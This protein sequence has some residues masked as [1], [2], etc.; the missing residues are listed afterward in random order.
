MS[1]NTSYRSYWT[2]ITSAQAEIVTETFDG[3]P[4]NDLIDII[5]IG[6]P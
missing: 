6:P 5:A 2:G 1:I 4:I 3:T